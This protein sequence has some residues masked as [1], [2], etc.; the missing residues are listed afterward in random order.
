MPV[1]ARLDTGANCHDFISQSVAASLIANG[2]E[3]VPTTGRVCSAFR[4]EGRDLSSSVKC[5]YVVM[6]ILTDKTES[7]AIQPVTL[8]DLRAPL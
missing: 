5:K 8:Q 3:V 4:A 7:I 6:N 2:A 1:V